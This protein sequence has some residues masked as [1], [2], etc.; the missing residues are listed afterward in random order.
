MRVTIFKDLY[1][2]GKEDAH[3]IP[4]A[5]ALNRIQR[6]NSATTIELVRSGNKDFKTKLPIV[7]FS[8]EFSGR[9]DDSLEKHSGFIVLDFDHINVEAS[10]A[11]LST[12][13]YVY[14]CWVS[15]SGD[16]LKA[17]VKITHPER[18]RDHF[19]ALKNYFDR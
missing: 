7:L 18:H 2:R 8:G 3:T 12:D 19:R 11:A 4:I 9:T 13:P 15:P 5:Q 1:K 17:L 16:G 10:K 14:S 6:G